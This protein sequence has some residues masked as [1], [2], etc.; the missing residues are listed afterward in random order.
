MQVKLLFCVLKVP[1]LKLK[2]EV[3]E[4]FAPRL[5]VPPGELMRSAFEK[6]AP[7][8]EIVCVFLPCI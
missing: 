3:E 2:V 7:E 6:P 8:A 1:L 4:K 5:T